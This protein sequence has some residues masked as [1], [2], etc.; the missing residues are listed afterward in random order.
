MHLFIRIQPSFTNSISFAIIETRK[1]HDYFVVRTCW[2]RDKDWPQS[3]FD[4]IKF[5]IVRQDP[6]I[7]QHTAECDAGWVQRA[8]ARIRE[9]AVPL[10]I[11]PPMG[12]DGVAY[13]L[14]LGDVF[15]GITIRWWSIGP[16]EWNKL[17][18]TVESL[19]RDLDS[20][21]F[22]FSETPLSFSYTVELVWVPPGIDS[23][24]FAGIRAVMPQ[25]ANIPVSE[26]MTQLVGQTRLHVGNF[27]RNEAAI[28][29]MQARD[30][31]MTAEMYRSKSSLI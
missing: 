6:T 4:K 11:K 16:K 30:R 18:E 3:T 21:K 5:D 24:H 1:A 9:I 17:I 19:I 15:G 14:T 13:E 23:S 27:G 28:K 2:R 20:D 8:I 25:L 29:C 10:L 31:G 22:S 26:L 12:C 7:E